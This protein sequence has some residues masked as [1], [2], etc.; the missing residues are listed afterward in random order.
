MFLIV[1]STAAVALAQQI[2]SPGLAFAVGFVSHFLFDAIPH[3]DENVAVDNDHWRM[4][5]KVVAIAL[6]DVILMVGTFVALAGAGIVEFSPVMLAAAL[7]GLLPDA[8]QIPAI[9]WP[10][11]TPRAL[12]QYRRIHEGIH[13][14][15]PYN[16]GIGWGL[17]VQGLTLA[18]VVVSLI[19]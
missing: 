4:V 6:V 16:I 10:D 11:A 12:K 19:R 5:K 8:L 3:G 2:T 18:I 9:V 14:V 17:L 15:T 13:N 1:H 7:G